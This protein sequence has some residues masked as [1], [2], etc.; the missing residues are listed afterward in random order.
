MDKVHETAL[1]GNGKTTELA[2]G[3]I[4]I[5]LFSKIVD[6]NTVK[7]LMVKT[8]MLREKNMK[9]LLYHY[10]KKVYD[11]ALSEAILI[12]KVHNVK[13][14]NINND[15]LLT[16]VIAGEK[17]NPEHKIHN[18]LKMITERNIAIKE[19]VKGCHIQIN[20][21]EEDEKL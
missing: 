18:K 19:D 8:I 13:I 11:L 5:N 1:I 10:L 12:H 7:P 4:T 14:E 9:G 20:I 17:L 3:D 2:F 16:A 6:I 21:V 15:Y